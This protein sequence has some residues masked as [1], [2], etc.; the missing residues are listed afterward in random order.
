MKIAQLDPFVPIVQR[1]QVIYCP[2]L[3]EIGQEVFGD[4]NGIESGL[5]PYLFRRFGPSLVSAE[6]S[7][8][9]CRYNLSLGNKEQI[10]WFISIPLSP[11]KIAECIEFW[12]LKTLLCRRN[13]IEQSY[14]QAV[15]LIRDLRR[16]VPIG[17]TPINS[18]GIIRGDDILLLP[19]WATP[20]QMNSNT[21]E[22]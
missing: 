6:F 2:G 10:D 11:Q 20:F 9:L 8:E 7:I 1:Y 3:I 22:S 18:N 13:H 17:L 12:G 15:S 4:S 21:T 19:R 5:F 16:P 14:T